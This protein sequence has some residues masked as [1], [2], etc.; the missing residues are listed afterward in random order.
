MAIFW[1]TEALP[2][3]VTSLLPVFL[4]PMVG[5]LTVK[6]TAQQYINVSSY[7]DSPNMKKMIL[8]NLF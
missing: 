4:F 7:L 8:F 1:I 6:A 5:L 2:I 3:A